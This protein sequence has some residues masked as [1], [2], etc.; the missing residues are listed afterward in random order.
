M[1]LSITWQIGWD[2]NSITC[3]FSKETDFHLM[4]N[5]FIYCGFGR[6]AELLPRLSSSCLWKINEHPSLKLRLFS[7]CITIIHKAISRERFKGFTLPPWNACQPLKSLKTM[8]MNI[9]LMHFL[10][11]L[12]QKKIIP[13]P[14]KQFGYGSA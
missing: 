4:K 13:L 5:M 10:Y 2:N 14:E 9:F 11:F 8:N 7:T 12:S 3:Y 1:K 6:F